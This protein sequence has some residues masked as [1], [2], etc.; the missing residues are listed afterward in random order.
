MMIR[1]P[2]RPTANLSRIEP[3][4]LH[5]QT[6]LSVQG[7]SSNTTGVAIER[8]LGFWTCWPFI[9][10]VRALKQGDLK[11]CTNV[12]RLPDHRKG[13]GKALVLEGVKVAEKDHVCASVIASAQAERLYLSC[14]FE[15]VGWASEGD[16]NP[17]SGLPGGRVL[18]RDF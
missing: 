17:L 18:F 4:M 16:G 7:R 15:P 8:R 1:L 12:N 2:Q 3:R 13:Y 6:F 9:P 10:I 11:A 5:K 14:G